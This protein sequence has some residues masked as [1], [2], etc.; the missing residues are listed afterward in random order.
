MSGPP[1]LTA[2]ELESKVLAVVAELVSELRGHDPH[3]RLGRHDSLERDLGISSLERVEL[4]VRLERAC[5]VR[6]ADAVMVDAESPADLA[7]ALQTA[8]PGL[9]ERL[10]PV[11]VGDRTATGVPTAAA[12]LVEVLAWHAERTPDRV[13]IHLREDD[14]RETPL[15]Y[16]ELWQAAHHVAAGLAAR[17]LGRHDTVA[18]MLRTERAFFFSFF[19][20]L[21]AGCVPVP[22][23]PP[24]RADR[25]QEYAERQVAILRNAAAR[26]LVTFADVERV[27][28]LLVGQVPS[29]SAVVTP[30]TLVTDGAAAPSLS[31]RDTG[32]LTSDDPALIQYTSGSTGQP[33]GVQLSH[34]N[35][36]A[37]VRALEAGLEIDSH[38]VGVSWLP[39]YHDMGLIGAWL[40]LLYV[41]RPLAL[42][43]PLA[44]LS[45]PS[46]W[47]WSFHAH[48][49]TIS[50]APNFAYDLCAHRVTD[51]EIEGLDLSSVRAL[52]NGAEAVQPD[53]LDRFAERFAPYGLKREALTP[54]Y[55]L[56]ECSVG[57]ATPP[58]GR[59]ARI[60]VIERR[61]YQETGIARQSTVGNTATTFRV[62]ACGRALPGHQIRVVDAS[63]RPVPERQQGRVEFRG[64]SATSGY[65]HN[66]DAT[67]ELIGSDGWLRT[68]DLGYLVEG[69]IYLTGRA[70]ELIIKGGRNIQPHEA[71]VV[72][73]AVDGV[74][75]G[76]VAAFGVSD[77]TRGTE[78]FVIVAETRLT[79]PADRA[80][81]ETMIT[82]SV[83]SALGIPPDVVV[84]A[85]PGAVL[86]TSSGKIRRG[87]TREAFVQDR[88]SARRLAAVQ[89]ASLTARAALGFARRLIAR[90]G[91]LAFTGWVLAV[92]LVSGPFVWGILAI[93]PRGL[94]VNRCVG[95]WARFIF[96]M[97]GCPVDIAGMEHLRD[98]DRAVF[99]A[100]H[101]S[102]IDPV[103]IM[104]SVPTRLRF[105]VKAKLAGYPF[106]GTAI[107]K[108]GH[109]L[110][111]REHR[112]EQMDGAGALLTPLQRGES[113]FVFPEGTFVGAPGL[114]PFRL[115]AFRAAVDVGCP[116]VPVAIRGT[117]HILPADRRT[118]KRGRLAVTVGEP[119]WPT[120]T[121]WEEIVRLRDETRRF[122]ARESGESVRQ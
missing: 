4:L 80:R 101:S 22:I 106:L 52:L 110:I 54:V 109:I 72:A 111:G 15:T 14:G 8:S 36:L 19:G 23:Y 104:A 91:S 86:K 115:G 29:L 81:L 37:N 121:T 71:E 89:W 90:S 47:L 41:G 20:T 10:A 108:A 64:P 93:G 92:L 122:I 48:R 117:R 56:A 76:C 87:A 24:F 70:K 17:G 33:K 69:E 97:T 16:G 63:G 85:R 114:L 83:S 40:G 74:R 105:A 116:V 82:T 61:V 35:L 68:G 5:G 34:A 99:V 102:F 6:L 59:G 77:T 44:F 32:Q 21:L 65:Y 112:G 45:R 39:L 94:W 75:K 79:A 100:N 42:M 62:V 31:S 11:D 84:L 120:G 95:G 30:D 55:G 28:S 53:T 27:A 113:L 58:M 60:D 119:I 12:T 98:L 2:D 50:A 49:G 118:L 1:R 96:W 13:H 103:L 88:L 9:V 46:R 38:D 78:R 7:A 57:V 26:I 18:L 51:D 25:I 67:H 43:S 66:P 73:A 107:R 3:R